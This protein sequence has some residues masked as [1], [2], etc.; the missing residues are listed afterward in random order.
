MTDVNGQ[1]E[2]RDFTL[3]GRPKTRKF[4]IDEDV[5]DAVSVIPLGLM[6]DLLA[7]SENIKTIVGA[8]D[9]DVVIDRVRSVM[10][11]L[12][13]ETAYARFNQRL[14]D[15][16]NPIG[17]EH[18][19]PLLVWLVEGYAVRPTQPS[20]PSSDGSPAAD[21]STSSTAGASSI[22][23]PGLNLSPAGSSI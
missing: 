12:L 6:K 22:P 5:F 15:R 23:F 16:T 7:A 9:I 1:P 19:G 17:I 10:Q 2:I 13:V 14:T 3:T 21:D 20:L 4:K 11:L 8:N 18:I